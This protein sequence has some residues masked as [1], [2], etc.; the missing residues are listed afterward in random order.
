MHFLCLL[1]QVNLDLSCKGLSDLKQG[2]I[3]TVQDP[4]KSFSEDPLRML[5]ALQFALR[6]IFK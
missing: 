5:R 3:R 1:P 6:L 4:D 2:I